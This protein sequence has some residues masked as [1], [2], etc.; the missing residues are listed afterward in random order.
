M[1]QKGRGRLTKILLAKQTHF[2]E[3]FG[4]PFGKNTFW[5]NAPTT[6]R[7][8]LICSILSTQQTLLFACNLY[9]GALQKSINREQLQKQFLRF[10]MIF[11]CVLMVSIIVNGYLDRYGSIWTKF[12]LKPSIL[13]P[14]RNISVNWAHGAH[15]PLGWGTTRRELKVPS[16]IAPRNPGNG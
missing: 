9:L 15:G 2:W 11:T 4:Q 16:G 10:L 12:Q 8:S 3:F 1:G 13:T 14:N 7:S 5:E 6:N